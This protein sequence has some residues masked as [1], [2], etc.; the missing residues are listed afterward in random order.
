MKFGYAGYSNVLQLRTDSNSVS[1][2]STEPALL[3]L[4]KTLKYLYL[5]FSPLQDQ[6]DGTNFINPDKFV[7][8]PNGHIFRKFKP[9]PIQANH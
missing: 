1:K 7:F 3:N 2:L 5:L 6:K 9:R 4:A 8:T